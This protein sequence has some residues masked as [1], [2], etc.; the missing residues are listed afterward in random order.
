MTSKNTN[1]SEPSLE[2]AINQLFL[3]FL[4]GKKKIDQEG[5]Y[6]DG[7]LEEELDD[8]PLAVLPQDRNGRTQRILLDVEKQRVKRVEADKR[9]KN[10]RN[11]LLM[12]YFQQSLL[13]VINEKLENSDNVI[14]D[15]LQLR[16]STVELLKKLLAGEPRYSVL[17]SLLE[18]NIGTRNRLLFLVNSDNFMSALGRD[19]RY[20]RDIQSA[21]G[22][23]GTDVLRYVVPA[24]LF[25]Y[26]INAYSHHN[27]LFAKKLWRYELTLGQACIALMQEANYRRPYE[28]MLLSAMVN[29]AYV[30][31]YQQYL[32]SF[33]V[34]RSAC[35]NKARDKGE[36]AQHDFFYEIQSDS[37]SLQ[38]LLVSQSSLKLSLSIATNIFKQDFP[39][40][41]NALKEEVEQLPFDDRSTVGKILFSAVRFAK[42]DQLRASRLFKPQ[43]LEDY[44]R[45]SQID[46][47]T[48]K[49][50]LRQEL[51]RFKPIWP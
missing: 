51:F 38:A 40:L 47:T 18:L 25:K 30:A 15:Q 39:H 50:L 24:L 20:V 16:E 43:W 29:F 44:L 4:V 23:I 3:R 1:T 19:S 34:V 13:K 28:G 11:A 5:E 49:N 35:L 8:R 32:T 22:L 26:R 7:L 36:K 9:L 46:E 33:E 10:K 37:A 45:G 21:I 12:R 14:N 41:V 48:Y 42:Y 2:D 31:G 27:A 17:A 6:S